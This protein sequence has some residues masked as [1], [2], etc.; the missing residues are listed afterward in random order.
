MQH[1]KGENDRIR[2]AVKGRLVMKALVIAKLLLV[3]ALFA[4]WSDSALAQNAGN[5][6]QGVL[7]YEQPTKPGRNARQ[8]AASGQYQSVCLTFRGPI[9]PVS[10]SRPILPDATCHCGGATGFTRTPEGTQ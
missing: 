8:A 9:C 6:Q 7:G 4:A 3:F 5:A 10:S 2:Q 1:K